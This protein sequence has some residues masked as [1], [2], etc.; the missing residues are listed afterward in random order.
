MLLEFAP[1]KYALIADT[2]QERIASGVYPVGSK[3]PSEAQLG[4]EF[5][6]S[7]PTVVRA[8]GI[9]QRA[10]L[11]EATQGSGRFVRQAGPPPEPIDDDAA[12]AAQLRKHGWIVVSPEQV[13]TLLPGVVSHLRRAL[14]T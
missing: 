14:A 7:R 13:Q 6:A 3:I 2:V 9:L 12:A 5:Q 1:P 8:L 10:G 4:V 11:L